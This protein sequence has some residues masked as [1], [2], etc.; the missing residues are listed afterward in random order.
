MQTHRIEYLDW[1]QGV[2][3]HALH[4]TLAQADL[5]HYDRLLKDL[6]NECVSVP[7]VLDALCQ[8]V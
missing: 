3:Q 7:L 8:Q 1:L 4:G 2:Q 5:R 6:P